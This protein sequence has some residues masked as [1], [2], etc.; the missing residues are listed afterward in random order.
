MLIGLANKLE[1]TAPI[2]L[3]EAVNRS[4]LPWEELHWLMVAEG[5]NLEHIPVLDALI[6]S[7]M[8]KF[9]PIESIY[10]AWKDFKQFMEKNRQATVKAAQA[11][12]R[13]D[14]QDKEV[15]RMLAN[16]RKND[17]L[18]FEIWHPTT[19]KKYSNISDFRRATKMYGRE[20][21]GDAY[22][23]KLADGT[24]TSGN[25]LDLTMQ[26]REAIRDRVNMIRHEAKR[27]GTKQFQYS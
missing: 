13:R 12:A 2:V 3:E 20:E 26:E 5:V 18:G 6:R 21:V 14:W 19:G 11:A 22:E 23:K 24:A 8:M 9:G 16:G 4:V 27:P 15:N 17:E 10:R 1:K 7:N 25:R